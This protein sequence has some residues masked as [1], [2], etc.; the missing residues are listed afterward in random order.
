MVYLNHLVI[1]NF[2]NYTFHTF[3]GSG[4]SISIITITLNL[5]EECRIII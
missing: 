5:Y 1:I 3:E 2:D 4:L